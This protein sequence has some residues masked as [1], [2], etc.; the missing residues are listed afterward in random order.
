MSAVTEEERA[1]LEQNDTCAAWLNFWKGPCGDVAVARIQMSCIH[2]HLTEG[3]VCGWHL[4]S[5]RSNYKPDCR[6]CGDGVTTKTLLK[7]IDLPRIPSLAAHP[8]HPMKR[9][10]E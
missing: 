3:P 9:R 4:E 5:A 7:V 6:S 2:E 8:F 10:P 1:L